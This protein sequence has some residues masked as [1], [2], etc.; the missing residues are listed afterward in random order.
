MSRP[1]YSHAALRRLIHPRSVAV[2]GASNRPRAFGQRV[3]ENL[4]GF[5]GAILPVNARYA[6]VAGHACYPSL[7]ALPQTPDLVI[8]AVPRDEVE[9]Q[10]EV[11]GQIGAGGV[12]VFAS[13]FAEMGC[14]PYIAMQSRIVDK[15][16]AAGVPLVGPNNIGNVNWGIGAV[17]TF[18]TPMTA[19]PPVE[20]PA[21]GL[22]SQ[23][24]ALG[25]ALGQ[26]VE[27][28]VA[29]SHVLTCGNSADVDVADYVAY[30][31]E[32]P[33]CRAIACLFE[34]MAEPGRMLQ[35]CS[36]AR[37]A[38]KAVVVFKIATGAQGAAAAMSHTGSLAGASDVYAA[39]FEQAG[40]IV[41]E[42][43]EEL[44]ETAAFFA[45]AGPCGQAGVAVLSTSGGA[46][47]MCADKAEANEVP[48]P[49]PAPQTTDILLELIPE[50]GSARNPCD[51]TAQ[52]V[53]DP[54][55]FRRC[56]NALMTDSNYGALVVPFVYAYEEV[57]PRVNLLDELART[58]GKPACVVWLPLWLE[59][60][61]ARSVDAGAHVAMFRSMD[62][63]F[64]TLARWRRWS[65]AQRSPRRAVVSSTPAAARE[66]VAKVLAAV[67]GTVVGERAAKA[68]FADYGLP[69]VSDALVVSVEE[70]LAVAQDRYPV[71]LKAESP[72]I[73][74]KTEA[75]VVRLGIRDAAAVRQA[76]AE[77]ME[78][79]GRVAAPSDIHGVLVQPMV[80]SGLEV[81]VGARMDPLF[82]P[83]V[84][85]GL[86]GVLVELMRDSAIALA[87][88]SQEEAH[89]M[90]RRLKGFHLFK[91]FRGS[92]AID[93]DALAKIIC[94]IGD[95][96]ADHRDIVLELDVNPL[97]CTADAIVGVDALIALRPASER[98]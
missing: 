50:F 14:E 22:V 4:R 47:I 96:A 48:L 63:C 15:A 43:Y 34:G 71:V 52:V 2:V 85:V 87:P 79:A 59:G 20:A 92:P 60:P 68:L 24:G 81:I 13:G 62:N 19:P 88:V 56:A 6:E 83:L 65:E 86:G 89:A 1:L 97:I 73:P 28:G 26:A 49:Q 38:G 94:R 3:F 69:M 93:L 91:G 40:A 55:P 98:R 23:S 9:Q 44:L 21:V 33:A 77:V 54:V 36:L 90:L 66:R 51:V 37:D 35:A 70:A 12:I 82:G 5:R 84:V 8:L 74:H 75:G 95:F 58:T 46:A 76:Y 80:P 72:R 42:H 17:C 53:S 67:P 64:R 57:L 11:C 78:N 25:F 61:G 31:A 16:R 18:L 41:V 39:A 27:H 45:K 7:A 32:D 10:I 30:L 29:L